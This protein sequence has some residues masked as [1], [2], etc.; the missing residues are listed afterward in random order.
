VPI[1]VSTTL[2][3]DDPDISLVTARYYARDLGDD[4]A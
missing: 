1:L 4:R 3:E 2:D